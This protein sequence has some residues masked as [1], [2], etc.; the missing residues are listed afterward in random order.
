M[1]CW[2]HARRKFIEAKKLQG[3]NKTGKADVVL[4]LIQ[5]LY[6]I[7]SRLKDKSADESYQTR[8]AQSKPILDKLKQWLENI[9]Q[10]LLVI[11]NSLMPPITWQTSGRNSLSTLMMGD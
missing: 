2:A 4:S 10:T 7:E 1:G 6:G 8:Q 5:K 3:K 9:S 11:V